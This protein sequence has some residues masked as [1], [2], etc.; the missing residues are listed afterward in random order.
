MPDMRTF[1]PTTSDAPS[2]QASLKRAL[3]LTLLLVVVL[4]AISLLPPADTGLS[5]PDAQ[6]AAASGEQVQALVTP[7]TSPSLFGPGYILVMILLAAAGGGA[8]WLKRT[9]GGVAST[10]HLKEIGRLRVGQTQ[11]IQL[12]SCAGEVLLLGTTPTGVNLLKSFPADAFPAPSQSRSSAAVAASHFEPPAA[13]SKP[14]HPDSGSANQDHDSE[15]EWTVASAAAINNGPDFLT[16]LRRYA[17]RK[18]Y[19]ANTL[20]PPASTETAN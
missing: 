19:R 18:T 13:K 8:Y 17:D 10:G 15:P 9:T 3:L 14:T 7:R 20:Y 12:V 11:Q 2:T 5:S 1:F 6:A 16:V 4:V